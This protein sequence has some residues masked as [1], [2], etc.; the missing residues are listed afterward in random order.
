MIK[1]ETNDKTTFI[2]ASYENCECKIDDNKIQIEISQLECNNISTPTNTLTTCECYKIGKMCLNNEILK[3]YTDVYYDRCVEL[4]ECAISCYMVARHYHKPC[5][6]DKTKTIAL[7]IHMK[8]IVNNNDKCGNILASI[9][10]ML[11][12]SYDY[13]NAKKYMIESAQ[14]HIATAHANLGLY[15]LFYGVNHAKMKEH[16]DI[17]LDVKLHLPNEPKRIIHY[18]YGYY[19][20]TCEINYSK[21]LEHYT[22][23]ADAGYAPAQHELGYI[24]AEDSPHHEQLRKFGDDYLFLKDGEQ[25]KK[26]YGMALAN[27]YD[28]TITHLE[29]TM[30]IFDFYNLLKSI[31]SP[32][33]N[34]INKIS[35]IEKKPKFADVR[36]RITFAE[37]YNIVEECGICYETKLCIAQPCCHTCCTTCFMKINKCPF[38]K[39]VHEQGNTTISIDP[40]RFVIPATTFNNPSTAELQQMHDLGLGSYSN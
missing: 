40:V 25:S 30:P 5:N 36:F 14:K 26:Y 39:Q 4:N 21:M 18:K 35:E 16:F 28:K 1:N 19:Y 2:M 31:N 20:S 3:K 24:Y 34:I 27:G 7:K 32:T 22:Q 12:H 13:S 9:G 23:S 29:K 11:M 33:Q 15:Y 10:G 17:A 6:F 8:T 38:C 37:K